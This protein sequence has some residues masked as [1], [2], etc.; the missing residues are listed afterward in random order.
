[1]NTL[2]TF[3]FLLSAFLLL[4]NA[5]ET[6]L[7]ALLEGAGKGA[8]VCVSLV[9]TYSVWLG[10]MRVWEDSGVT[11]II[12]RI[13]KPVTKW[14]FKTEDEEALH[15]INM[16]VSVNLLGISGA[17]TP[18]GIQAAQRLDK[19]KN[20]EYSSAMLFVL[21]ATSIQILPTSIISVR[22]ALQSAAPNNIII[23]TMLASLL[24]TLLGIMLIKVFIHPE[25]EIKKDF[26]P[27]PKMVKF[28]K[29][30]GA[31]I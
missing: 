2:F 25:T 10:L 8:S 5:P 30:K 14:L 29:R 4:C 9:A 26:I 31:G 20:A 7:S 15:A 12:S 22:V 21:N 18:Y 19:T 16:N 11:K 27:R 1:M 13:V 24:S 3:I 28:S 23:P 17:A 6:F